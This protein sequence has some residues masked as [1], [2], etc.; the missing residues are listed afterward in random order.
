MIDHDT[1][2]EVG[3][4][5]SH[6]ADRLQETAATTPPP[7]SPGHASALPS[8]AARPRTREEILVMSNRRLGQFQGKH[9]GKRCVII[10]NGPSLNKMDLSFLEHEITFGMNRIYLMFDKWKFRPT[11][12]VAV[13]P[14]VIEQSAGE[15]LNI[16]APKFL[17]HKGIPF[18]DDPREINFLQSI[19]EWFFAKDPRNGICEGWTV[20]YV[21][22]QLAYF[23]G[24]SEV[25][26]I[27]VDH[28]FVTPGDPN[29][30]VVSEGDDPNHFHPGYFGKG[31]RWHLPDLEHSE[32]SYRMAKRAFEAENRRILDATVDGKLTIFPKVDYR[33]IFCTSGTPPTGIAPE[34]ASCKI[35]VV[36][37]TYNQGTYIEQTIR[38]VIDQEYPNFEH[39]V[40]DGGSTDGTTAVLKHYPHLRWI[41]EKDRGQSDALNKGLRMATG[42][43]IAWINSDDWYEPGVFGAIAEFFAQNPDKNVVMGNCN[44]INE[45]GEIFD[46]VINHERGFGALKTHWIARSIP[47]QPAIFFRKKLLDEFGLLDESLHFAMDYDLWMRFATKNRFYHLDRTVANY[48]FHSEAKG[49]DQDWSKFVP[50]WEAVCSRYASPAVSV[51]IPCYNYAHY[52]SDAVASVI[53]QTLQDFEIIIVNDGSTDN[54]QEVAEKLI[55]SFPTHTIRLINTPNSGNP[56]FPRNIGVKES[57]GSY[58]VFLDADDMLMPTFLQESVKLLDETPS[59][60]IAYTDQKYFDEK[61]S[62]DVSTRDYDF[63]NLLNANFMSY[64][65]LFRRKVWDDVGGVPTDVGYEDWDFW[66]LSGLN[67]HRAQRIPKPLFCYRQHDTGRFK[68]DLVSRDH[69]LKA[70]IVLKHRTAYPRERVLL[71]EETVALTHKD[72]KPFRVIA[73]IS[74]HNEG[75]VI[76]HVIGDLVQ[77]GIEVYLIN[78]CSTDNTVEEASKWLGKGL[79]HIENFPQDAGYPEANKRQYIWHHILRRKEELAAQ[80]DADWFIHS[81]ADEFRESPWPRLT[82][83]QAI[84]VADRMGYNALDF[85]LL[86]FRPVDNR[87][88]PGA[89]V[90]EALRYY[91]GCEEFNTYQIKAWKNLSIP[92][93]IFQ[94]GGHNISF[95]GRTVCPVKFLLRHYPI[96]GQSHGMRKVFAERKERFS[97]EEVQI[98][99]HVQY[100]GVNDVNHNFLHDPANLTPY[101]GDRVR[102]R[103]LSAQALEV[104]ASLRG[105]KGAPAEALTPETAGDS[106]APARADLEMGGRVEIPILIE[107]A[108][109]LAND[110]N[111]TEAMELYRQALASDPGNCPALV[112]IGVVQIV[113]GNYSEAALAFSKALKSSPGHTKAL[114]GLGLARSGQGWRSESFELYKQALEAD[115]ENLTAL[116]ELLKAAYELDRLSEAE[117]Y[118]AGYL[119][120]HPA[121]IHILF[122]LAGLQ[123]RLGRYASAIDALER[124]LALEP[125]YEG[126]AE[127]AER[128]RFAMGTEDGKMLLAAGA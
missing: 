100:S 128:V 117:A 98:G 69:Y 107:Q 70:Q 12:Y 112:G 55:A 111:A 57:R 84:Q 113:E 121:D 91:E 102:L 82:L 119:M 67:G 96:R 21:A 54:S 90:R 62:W 79:L 76:Y 87:F 56:A 88:V 92:V 44:L 28:H 7:P 120:Y 65:S 52:L 78:H 37:P 48:R 71:A 83:K 74:A 126:G 29:K 115:P 31:I 20:T 72:S 50:E 89:D 10:G 59:I 8:I 103:I 6:E 97:K 42:D 33:E 53:G 85:E 58:V 43:I 99:W 75:D 32:G 17:S 118:V 3:R 49:G 63:G 94:N 93:S 1:A 106:H 16:A 105:P 34:S 18:F 45:Q 68:N 24:F 4:P 39:V 123:Y 81:D 124:L 77:Q 108:N 40:I 35:S 38:S 19:P 104:A 125:D 25:I 101:D 80:L 47:T 22:M 14:L 116:H 2:Q 109:A 5:A 110:G 60:S 11:Y 46:T 27:G 86:N 36:T 64:C 41:S 73:L 51:V 127:L 15:I 30:E 122:S 66:I 61:S 23:M 13:N 9:A 114:C 95:E 26:L